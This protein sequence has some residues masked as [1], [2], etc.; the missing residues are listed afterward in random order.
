MKKKSVFKLS[1]STKV[2]MEVMVFPV[3]CFMVVVVCVALL[4]ANSNH[5]DN[6]AHTVDNVSMTYYPVV[7][8]KGVTLH[9]Y[10]H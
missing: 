5:V 6:G 1:P 4:S 3:F 7:T 10:Y 9:H 8:P 2:T